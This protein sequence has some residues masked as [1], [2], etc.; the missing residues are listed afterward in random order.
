MMAKDDETSLQHWCEA[1]QKSPG[2]ALDD[3][4]FAFL[5]IKGLFYQISRLNLTPTPPPPKPPIQWV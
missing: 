1:N 3:A 2:C 5:H 4:R